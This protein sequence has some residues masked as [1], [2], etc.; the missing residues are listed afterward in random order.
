MTNTMN[1]AIAIAGLLLTAASAAQAQTLT[2]QP[3]TG[4]YISLGAGVQ[5][6]KRSFGSSGTFTSFNE[7][8]RFEINQNV[9]SGAL[10]D[11]G[12]GYQFMKHLA[13]GISV[14]TVRNKSAVAAAASIPD[15]V[16]FGRFTTVT[17]EPDEDLTQSTL[18]INLQIIYTMPVADRFDL[19]IAIG[20]SVI[21][22]KLE[23]ATLAVTPNSQTVTVGT[24]SQSKTTAKAGNLGVDL[25]FRAN[26]MYNIGG[27]VRYAGGEVDLPAF[28]KMKVGGV[29][30]GGIVRYRF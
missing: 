9:G 24:E 6:Q 14:W 16:F 4:A 8:G 7:T 5:P 3:E 27:F 11:V 20:P 1:R 19:A 28:A 23:V 29:Q 21:R 12:A 18:G 17:A 30:V 22:T 10:F 15:P 13:A 2:P 26:E 25:T